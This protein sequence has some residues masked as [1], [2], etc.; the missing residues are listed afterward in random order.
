MQLL[1]LLRGDHRVSKVAF[2]HAS[3]MAAATPGFYPI[4]IA[5]VLGVPCQALAEFETASID[6]VIT[7]INIRDTTG[8]KLGAVKR[9]KRSCRADVIDADEASRRRLALR[10]VQ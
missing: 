10:L 5:D 1:P 6:D 8:N 7:T 2:F 4:P 3:T 9:E